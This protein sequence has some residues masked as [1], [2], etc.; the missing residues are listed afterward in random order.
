MTPSK[1]AK[2]LGCE[3]LARVSIVSGVPVLTLRDWFVSRP[4]VFEAVC[5][6]VAHLDE[7]S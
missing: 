7:F 4:F 1:R 3:S 2:Q 6:K 5:Q